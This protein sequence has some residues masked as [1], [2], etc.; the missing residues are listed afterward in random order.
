[1][2]DAA[3]ALVAGMLTIA[4]P[5]VLP[6]LPILLGTSVGRTGGSR[7]F[8]I[9]FGFT[10]SFSV[11]ALGLGA[12]A[13]L[14]GLRPETW[15]NAATALLA[16]F[17]CLMVWPHLFERLTARFG[18]VLS[19]LAGGGGRGGDGRLGG[20]LVGASL[21]A[22]WTPCA[23]PVLGS[24][25]TLVATAPRLGWAATLLVCYAAGASIPMLAVAYGGQV[26]TARARRLVPYTQ[27]LQRG[28]GV[29]IILVA[30]AIHWRY[31]TSLAVWLSRVYPHAGAGL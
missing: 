29:V 17:G 19:R 21:G 8:F 18:G 6:T 20:F 24:I 27:Q 22:V 16:V 28:F 3:L 2:I 7:P 15:R 4:S 10:A 1:M 31:D 11:V 25:L 9:A 12:S 23:G 26:A 13:A 14:L 30:A 5:C